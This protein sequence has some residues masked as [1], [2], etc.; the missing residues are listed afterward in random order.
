[1]RVGEEI[2]ANLSLVE[3]RRCPHWE[4]SIATRSRAAGTHLNVGSRVGGALLSTNGG[5]KFRGHAFPGSIG[6]SLKV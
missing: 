3:S 4:A 1:M 2:V 5:F 6:A